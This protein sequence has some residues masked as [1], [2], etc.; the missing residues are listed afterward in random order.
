MKLWISLSGLLI[1]YFTY[2]FYLSQKEFNLVPNTFSRM[3]QS[4]YYDYRGVLN[5][6][7]NASIGSGPTHE[8]IEAAK[9]VGLDFVMLTDLNV[10]NQNETVEGYHGNTLVLL[11]SKFSYLDS[12]IIHY[13]TSKKSLGQNL[14]EAQVK[15]SDLLSQSAGSNTDDLLILA[16]PYKA[17]FSWTGDLPPGLD[18]FELINEK[19]LSYRSLETSKLSTLWSLLTYPFNPKLSFI[20][21]F[22]E[23]QEELE[24][25]DRMGKEHSAKVFAGAE[26]SARAVPLTNYLVKFPSY[27]RSFEFITTHVLLSS[28]LTG[29]ASG[30]KTKIFQAL[31]KG[32]SYICFESLGDPKGFV[33]TIESRGQQF[34]PGSSL[35]LS[36]GTQ[37]HV[38]LPAKPQS[39]FEIAIFKDGERIA[40]SNTV[41]ALYPITQAGRYRVQ[42]RLSPYLPLPD[43][44]RWITWIY[45]NSFEVRDPF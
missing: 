4:K 11:G 16:H 14:G 40:T 19:S 2:G 3:G 32:H 27:Q 31:K 15:I 20:R 37:L 30:D 38:S 42:V 22:Q 9:S 34:L 26:A 39:Y 10:F 44:I 28:E 24:L 17:G 18:G 7:T 23:P 43:A 13:S 29:N 8:V 41:E 36:P 5:V 12:R 25:M 35:V 45:T 21:L 6:H 1:L 33:A